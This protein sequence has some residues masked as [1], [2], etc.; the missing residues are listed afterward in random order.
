MY[1]ELFLVKEMSTSPNRCCYIAMQN[2]KVAVSQHHS[3]SV[4][5]QAYNSA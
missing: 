3:A 5:E 1:W 4:Q 2:E